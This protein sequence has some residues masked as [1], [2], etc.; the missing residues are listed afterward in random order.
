MHGVG[1]WPGSAAAMP[2]PNCLNDAHAQKSDHFAMC[3]RW[4]CTSNVRLCQ[5]INTGIVR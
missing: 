4:L 5:Q 3:A 2:T 1:I